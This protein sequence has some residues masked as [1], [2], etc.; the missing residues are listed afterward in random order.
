MADSNNKIK[1]S[2][3]DST[4]VG[5]ETGSPLHNA[6]TAKPVIKGK[7]FKPRRQSFFNEASNIG[8]QTSQKENDDLGNQSAIYFGEVESIEVGSRHSGGVHL[9]FSQIIEESFQI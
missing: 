2:T 9:D 6:Y 3:L 5:I 1:N 8:N 7:H 4:V